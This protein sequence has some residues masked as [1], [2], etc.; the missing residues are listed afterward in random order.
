M[1]NIGIGLQQ[2]FEPQR[3]K[4]IFLKGWVAKLVARRLSR[5]ALWVRIPQESQMGD[6]SKGG[7]NTLK[8]VKKYKNKKPLIAS[9]HPQIVL[10]A[11]KT[12]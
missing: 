2:D 11:L 5:Q 3:L 10:I 7:A 1:S 12:I 9:P 4:V 8:P 6:I